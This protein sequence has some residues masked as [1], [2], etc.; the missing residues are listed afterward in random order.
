MTPYTG[1]LDPLLPKPG[2]GLRRDEFI[3]RL[4]DVYSLRFED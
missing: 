1:A 3:A 2:S 4:T